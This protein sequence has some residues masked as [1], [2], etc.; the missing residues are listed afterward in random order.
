M[1]EG[2]SRDLQGSAAGT[3]PR[4]QCQRLETLCLGALDPCLSSSSI[5]SGVNGTLISATPSASAT[6]LAMQAGVLIALPSATPLAPSGVTG[7][8]GELTLAQ[9]VYA[10][11]RAARAPKLAQSAW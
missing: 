9:G 6:A 5:R 4:H 7:A 3:E 8:A 1:P 11:P 10:P 2:I